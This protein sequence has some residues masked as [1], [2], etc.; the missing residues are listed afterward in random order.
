MKKKMKSEKDKKRDV[1]EIQFYWFV[2]IEKNNRNKY[3]AINKT[4]QQKL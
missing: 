3:L 1:D 2:Q 4:P